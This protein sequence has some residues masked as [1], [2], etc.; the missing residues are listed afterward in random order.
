MFLMSRGIE[1]RA[2]P[3][4]GVDLLSGAG[5]A[6]ITLLLLA[7]HVAGDSDGALAQVVGLFLELLQI[8]L[9]LPAQLEGEAARR[10]MW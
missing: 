7:V 6:M 9:W 1:Y 2:V 10:S 8:A 5:D 3:L 4:L